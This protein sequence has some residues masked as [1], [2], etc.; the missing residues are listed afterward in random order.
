MVSDSF[1]TLGS[2]ISTEEDRAWAQQE[3]VGGT[4]L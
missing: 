2:V 3:G 1:S 4:L